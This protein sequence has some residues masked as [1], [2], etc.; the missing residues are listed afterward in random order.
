MPGFHVE[1]YIVH[2]PGHRGSDGRLRP[3]GIRSHETN[4]LLGS[5]PSKAEADQ[6]L[7]R[8]R[9]YKHN[10]GLELAA[11]DSNFNWQP[12]DSP[13]D[14]TE[15]VPIP[16][17][18]PNVPPQERT[19]TDDHYGVDGR[20][21]DQ[22]PYDKSVMHREDMPFG[23]Y[24]TTGWT[25]SMQPSSNP[26]GDTWDGPYSTAP[27]GDSL[28]SPKYCSTGLYDRL[29]QA[30]TDWGTQ[31]DGLFGEFLNSVSTLVVNCKRGGLSR[32][33]TR[34]AA[35]KS[36][37][38][39]FMRAE[40]AGR[41]L[42]RFLDRAFGTVASA[43][44]P[45]ESIESAVTDLIEDSVKTGIPA[46]DAESKVLVEFSAWVDNYPELRIAIASK[47]DDIY[48][49]K[50]ANA[51]HFSRFKKI[52]LLESGRKGIILDVKQSSPESTELEIYWLDSGN[53]EDVS[54]SD[55][56]VVVSEPNAEELRRAT[57]VSDPPVKKAAS[58]TVTHNAVN[59]YL[60]QFI[61]QFKEF[62]VTYAAFRGWC[63]ERG[64]S[65]PTTFA[66]ERTAVRLNYVEIPENVVIFSDKKVYVASDNSEAQVMD[67]DASKPPESIKTSDGK[68]LKLKP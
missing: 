56:N 36:Y 7:K 48:G 20:S 50:L 44:F 37:A 2:I 30:S 61:A 40:W 42:N 15:H 9:Y 23:E 8:M 52:T 19:E 32:A 35:E 45:V 60:L 58:I 29:F 22:S 14:Y 54:T 17:K 24:E 41:M 63:T 62:P 3:W 12:P 53:T 64:L 25:D 21:V 55:I 66:L 65:M 38:P 16:E 68:E 57:E 39:L 10:A 13:T 6:A 18:E 33:A 46:A 28:A 67:V 1:S 5:Y 43:K 59:S 47:L 51:A 31:T 4:K 27:E 34:T 26:T 11:G 49:A